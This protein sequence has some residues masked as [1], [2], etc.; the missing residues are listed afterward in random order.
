LAKRTLKDYEQQGS[1]FFPVAAQETDQNQSRPAM[2]ALAEKFTL[3][4]WA[5]NTLA[6]RYLKTQREHYFGPPNGDA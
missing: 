1:R 2:G 5:L 3:A 4:R 6:D